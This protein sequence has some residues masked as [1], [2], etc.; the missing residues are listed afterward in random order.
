METP[1]PSSTA[2]E[3]LVKING[4]LNTPHLLI[5]GLAVQYYCPQRVSKD[6]D[7]ICDSDTAHRLISILYPSNHYDVTDE[8]EDD[9]RPAYIIQSKTN[10]E[11]VVFI[12][13]KITEREPYKYIDWKILSYNFNTFSYQK[14]K[15]TNI[16]IPCIEAL[17]YT[18]LLSFLNR[19]I[20]NPEKGKV[21]LDDFI[22]LSN[23]VNFRSNYFIGLIETMKCKLHIKNMLLDVIDKYDLSLWNK[24]LL[25][26]LYELFGP[27]ISSSMPDPERNMF[28]E[29]FTPN[30]SIAFYDKVASYYDARNTK[31]LY[32]GHQAVIRTILKVLPHGG[33]IIDFGCGTGRLIAA[34]FIHNENISWTAVDGSKNMLSQFKYHTR[35][36]KMSVDL[37]HC[38]INSLDWNGLP[39]A[40]LC[41]ACFTLSSME[42]LDVINDI[43]AKTNNNGVLLIADIHP[44]RTIK[45]PYYDFLLPDGK[46]IALKPNPIYPDKIFEHLSCN[47]FLYESNISINQENGEDYAFISVF[48]N[49][50]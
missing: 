18:K 31:L 11:K 1:I 17:A 3:Q 23:N 8:N 24:S 27:T 9:L 37:M 42:S 47:G 33:T 48:R 50:K 5:G 12:G 15:L 14:N 13:P 35:N 29:V 41:M 34:H 38:D 43:A 21:D 25:T 2:K 39:K 40:D 22:N 20:S 45:S 30:N 6:I 46:K 16:A 36:S 7:L 10:R 32:E 28:N 49:T 4:Q 19:I 26:D 44:S